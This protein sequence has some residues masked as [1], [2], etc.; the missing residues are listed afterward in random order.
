LKSL[1]QRAYLIKF[2]LVLFKKNKKSPAFKFLGNSHCIIFSALND[3]EVLQGGLYIVDQTGC[4]QIDDLATTGIFYDQEKDLFLRALHAPHGP[5]GPCELLIY[6]P[7]SLLHHRHEEIQDPHSIIKTNDSYAIASTFT[8][9]IYFINEQAMILDSHKI[10]E[11]E[12]DCL[13]LNSLAFYNNNLYASTFTLGSKH[14]PW[15]S[16]SRNEGAVI[17][18]TSRDIVVKDITTPH[19][20]FIDDDKIMLCQSKASLVSVFD[21]SGDLIKNLKLN[22]FTRGLYLFNDL[23]LIGQSIDRKANSDNTWAKMVVADRDLK[24]VFYIKELPVKEIYDILV[25]PTKLADRLLK[26]TKEVNKLQIS[27]Q[28]KRWWK[29]PENPDLKI[30]S[31]DEINITY[32]AKIPSHVKKNELFYLKITVTNTS[33]YPFNHAGKFRFNFSYKWKP[34]LKDNEPIRTPL[35]CPLN[36]GKS[37][38]LNL[39]V[40]A[41]S[42]AGKYELTCSAVQENICWLD[43]LKHIKLPKGL[44]EVCD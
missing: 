12:Y 1:K 9:E 7:D 29:A 4:H 19:S 17:E 5:N 13:H 14:A 20:L 36:P 30:I 15:R 37:I 28:L 35:F 3:G 38:E 33:K 16:H 44:V 39:L 40:R 8:N 31:P 27:G 43:D 18:I 34:S 21:F 22:D 32:E 42:K 2:S 41:P 26:M 6:K 25:V 23:T 10:S 24:Q 11:S